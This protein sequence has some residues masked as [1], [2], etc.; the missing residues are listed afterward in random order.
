MIL[1]G[2]YYYMETPVSCDTCGTVVIGEDES[3]DAQIISDGD[4]VDGESS[5]FIAVEEVSESES[6]LLIEEADVFCREHIPEE[7]YEY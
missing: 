3:T 6:G 2:Q 4:S 5:F 7:A 1:Q